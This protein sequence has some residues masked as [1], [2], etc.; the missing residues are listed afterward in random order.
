VIH[1][2]FNLFMDAYIICNIKILDV[3]DYD[4]H[5]ANTIN[6]VFCHM[7]TMLTTTWPFNIANEK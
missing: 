2:L 1:K 7:L 4:Y 5:V 6:V 3:F